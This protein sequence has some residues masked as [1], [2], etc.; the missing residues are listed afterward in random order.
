MRRARIPGIVMLI[1]AGLIL[2]ATFL[3][4]AEI[5]VKASYEHSHRAGVRVDP[6]N[7][8]IPSGSW[9]AQPFPT[10]VASL[11]KDIADNRI[12]GMT[13]DQSGHIFISPWFKNPDTIFYSLRPI[14]PKV[15]PI[16]LAIAAIVAVMGL[17]SLFAGERPVVRRGVAAA[18]VIFLVVALYVTFHL[19]GRFAYQLHELQVHE[20]SPA[21]AGGAYLVIGGAV[22]SFVSA[23][24]ALRVARP[25]PPMPQ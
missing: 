8:L 9:S 18:H 23:L 10:A 16:T 1:G 22:L 6:P 12:E 21:L 7:V 2:I 4:W 20:S 3:P 25:V 14:D 5:N 17:A 24:A 13:V 15:G 19:A 11:R